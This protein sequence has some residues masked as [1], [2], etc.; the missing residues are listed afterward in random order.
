M[1]ILT[2]ETI[3]MTHDNELSSVQLHPQRIRT[4]ENVKWANLL[5][6]LYV[7][8]VPLFFKSQL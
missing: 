7:R 8:E 2:T 5:K 6:P 3:Y 4:L 1:I